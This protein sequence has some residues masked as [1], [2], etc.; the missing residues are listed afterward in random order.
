MQLQFVSRKVPGTAR[1]CTVFFNFQCHSWKT[2]NQEISWAAETLHAWTHGMATM[3][4]ILL[5][6]RVLDCRESRLT[7]WL[8][9]FDYGSLNIHLWYDTLKRFAQKN[10]KVFSLLTPCSNITCHLTPKM[11][12]IGDDVLCIWSILYCR[13]SI[14]LR[15]Y[16]NISLTFRHCVILSTDDISVSALAM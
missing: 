12:T 8:I 5:K 4:I 2:K 9:N 6:T 14:Y 13:K 15:M 7:W 1:L 10:F 11:F 3:V 16:S